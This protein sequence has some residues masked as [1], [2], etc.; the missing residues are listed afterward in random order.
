MSTVEPTKYD[1]YQQPYIQVVETV[2]E[3]RWNFDSSQPYQ[4]VEFPQV[5]NA[6][7][8]QENVDPTP[9]YTHEHSLV[10]AVF[11]RVRYSAPL[12]YHLKVF[13][14]SYEPLGRTNGW[15]NDYSAWQGEGKSSIPY[16]TICLAGKRIPL[17]PAMTRYLVAHEYGHAVEYY[18]NRKWFDGEFHKLRELY[19][20]QIR[21]DSSDRYGPGYWHANV[22]E[23]FANDFR[24]LVAR[25]ELEFW[26]H[27]GFE[28]PEK[29]TKVITFWREVQD[30]LLTEA[31]KER[32]IL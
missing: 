12:P 28:R 19:R 30:Y 4:Y 11:D 1:P 6:Y 25:Q 21:P 32:G 7:G 29:V 16:G 24:I 15:F 22:G 18:L 31:E 17:H 14:L 3:L 2:R 26:P 8:K 27:E 13:I 9:C 5:P 20:E 23:L 10:Q